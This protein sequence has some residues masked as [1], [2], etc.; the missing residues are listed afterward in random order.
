MRLRAR[1]PESNKLPMPLYSFARATPFSRRDI[2]V[3]VSPLPLRFPINYA[4]YSRYLR[5]FYRMIIAC[6]T[7][8]RRAFISAD[9]GNFYSFRTNFTEEL[10]PR[11]LY[12]S[13]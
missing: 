3:T 13:L 5:A 11:D 7:T 12:K 1:I 2:T 10:I 8:L 4:G 9:R 6:L